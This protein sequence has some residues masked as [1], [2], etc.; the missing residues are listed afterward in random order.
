MYKSSNDSHANDNINTYIHILTKKKC[1]LTT[2]MVTGQLILV[3]RIKIT[4]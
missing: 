4:H 3:F 1:T 2:N